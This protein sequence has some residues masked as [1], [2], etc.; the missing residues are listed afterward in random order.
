MQSPRV[1]NWL[2]LLIF[3][4]TVA[5]MDYTLLG[6][7][8]SHGLESK[9]YTVHLGSYTLGIPIL[10]LTF[11]GVLIVA[12]TAWKHLSSTM[13]VA[14]LKEMQQLGTMQ[15]LRAASV[16]I[17]FFSAVLFVPYIVGASAFWVQMSALSRA[18]P[19]LAAPLSGLLSSIQSLM[20]LDALTKLVI[21]QD[22]AAA[23]LVV[24][25]GLMGYVQRRNKRAR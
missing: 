3:V 22:T 9:F 1:R 23:A 12:I 2:T 18:I 17:F 13:P 10:G 6:H 8:M 16:A 4:A 20:D 5:V 11:V 25:S 7:L 15:V 24:I 14:A 21:S 19:Q